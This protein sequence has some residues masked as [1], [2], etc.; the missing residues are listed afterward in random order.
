MKVKKMRRRSRA[1]VIANLILS[2]LTYSKALCEYDRLD[3]ADFIRRY[4]HIL[5]DNW[6]SPDRI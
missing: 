3:Q 2:G 6:L 1:T 4:A 5:N